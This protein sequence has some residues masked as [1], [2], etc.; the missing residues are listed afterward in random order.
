MDNQFKDNVSSTNE[1]KK[2]LK[3]TRSVWVELYGWVDYAVMTFVVLL[4]LFVFLFKHLI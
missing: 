1:N 3:E 4:L 2:G